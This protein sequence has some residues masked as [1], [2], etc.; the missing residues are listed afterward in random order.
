[1]IFVARLRRS[2]LSAKAPY[3]LNS[4]DKSCTMKFVSLRRGGRGRSMHN[5]PIHSAIVEV[6]LC[7]SRDKVSQVFSNIMAGKVAYFLAFF[8]IFPVFIS[9][10][11]DVIRDVKYPLPYYNEVSICSCD[12][13]A[14]KCDTN[15][16]C[17]QVLILFYYLAFFLKVFIY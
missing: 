1:M 13:T 10:Q 17:D 3:Q 7:Y 9:C 14:H 6:L 15:C 5:S 4:S 16:C 11:R 8:A 2:A 12:L